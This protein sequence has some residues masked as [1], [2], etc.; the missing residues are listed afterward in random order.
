MKLIITKR[1]KNTRVF[2]LFLFIYIYIVIEIVDAIS[3]YDSKDP[4]SMPDSLRTRI[5]DEDQELASRWNNK[6]DLSG[7]VIGIPQEYYVDPL[8]ETVV[9]FWRQGIRFFKERGASIV[10]VS[11]PMTRFAL[12]AY[13]TVAL[14]EASSNLARYD[15]VRYGS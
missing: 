5:D 12:P 4:T 9:D 6:D 7:L 10:P 1:L 11:L 13:Y 3:A 15:G 2:Y 8:S 14:A